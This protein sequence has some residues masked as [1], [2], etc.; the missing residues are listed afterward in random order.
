MQMVI[1][2]G[3]LGTRLRSLTYKIPKVMVLVGGRPFLEYVLGLLRQNGLGKI[4]LCVGYLGNQIREYFKDGTDFGVNISYSFERG[5]ELLGTGGALKNAAHLLENEFMVLYGDTLLDIDY[6]DLIHCFHR[7]GKSGTIVTFTNEIK[8]VRN[9]VEI[10]G[11]NQVISYNKQQE[12][13][14]NCVDAGVLVFKKDIVNLMPD[15]QKFSLEESV[16][17]QLIAQKQF[18][19]YPTSQR[20]YDIGTFE[21]LQKFTKYLSSLK[22]V[23]K[24]G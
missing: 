23:D 2:A 14:A 1:L 20:F 3:G 13:K 5:K 15:G 22:S 8:I 9:N 19:A 17:P 24:E 4:V 18:M 21:R 7:Y 12:C 10:D 6:Q 11:K 16:Y